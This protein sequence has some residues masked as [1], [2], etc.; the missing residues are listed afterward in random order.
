MQKKKPNKNISGTH[1]RSVRPA[2][3]SRFSKL[4]GQKKKAKDEHPSSGKQKG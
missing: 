4:I 3:K 2:N 1:K